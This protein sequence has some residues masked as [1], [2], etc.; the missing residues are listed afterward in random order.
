MRGTLL[1]ILAL[2]GGCRLYNLDSKL[3]DQAG[4]IPAEQFARYGTE[5]ARAVAI[6]RAL[7]QWDGGQSHEAR[8]VQTT[9]AAEYARTLPGV[10]SVEVDTLGYRLTVVFESG[11]RTGIVPIA[12]G[13]A[14]EATPGIAGN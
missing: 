4:L 14:P 11:W 9:K 2:T 5:Q 8:A 1:A 6:G 3:S 13:I 10:R 12:D 7:A